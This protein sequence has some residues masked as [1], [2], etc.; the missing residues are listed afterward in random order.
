LQQKSVPYLVGA[1]L[2]AAF[3]QPTWNWLIGRFLDQ[4]SSDASLVVGAVSWTLDLLAPYQGHF[5]GIA[6]GL[7]LGV[8]LT[9]EKPPKANLPFDL[10]Q[11]VV[12]KAAH[13]GEWLGNPLAFDD[14]TRYQAEVHALMLD[15]RKNGFGVP[16]PPRDADPSAKLATA[17]Q[18]FLV[19]GNMLMSG[20]VNEARSTAKQLTEELEARYQSE[21][22]WKRPT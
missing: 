7:C 18:Y 19:V 6:I 20:H 11:R 15:L 8:V 2:I 17:R 4:A 1:F 21:P 3:V 22:P 13:I 16:N 12:S 14:Y 10:G 9:H 5:V